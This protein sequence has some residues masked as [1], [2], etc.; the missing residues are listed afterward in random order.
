[1]NI[2]RIGIIDND[3]LWV[4]NFVLGFLLSNWATEYKETT[5]AKI[6]ACMGNWGKLWKIQ[7]GQKPNCRFWGIGSKSRVLHVIPAHSTTK[8]VGAHP[9]HP[10]GRTPEPAP[11][12]TQFKGPARPRTS[13]ERAGEPVT[14]FHS[15]VL[16]HD[17]Q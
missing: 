2:K 9:S 10:S 13:R 5:R 17:S 15:P 8:G 4:I 1:M 12:V 14:C 6:T 16:Q 11:I 7:K 3:S